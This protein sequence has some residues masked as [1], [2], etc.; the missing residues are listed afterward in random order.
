MTGEITDPG[1]EPLVALLLSDYAVAL[2]SQYL[3]LYP[4]VCAALT[5][6]QRCSFLQWVVVNR[7]S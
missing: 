3:C 5:F 7:V 1:R 6:G 2:S 4:E